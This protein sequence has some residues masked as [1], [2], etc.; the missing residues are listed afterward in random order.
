MSTLRSLSDRLS[1]QEKILYTGSAPTLSSKTAVTKRLP[2][3]PQSSSCNN[4]S[5]P[6]IL[7]TPL[8]PHR[9]TTGR[10]QYWNRWCFADHDVPL[11]P[12]LYTVAYTYDYYYYYTAHYIIC[13]IRITLR[14]LAIRCFVRQSNCLRTDTG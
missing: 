2:G 6:S 3:R 10:D 12:P 5:L 8:P 9:T 7:T 1:T 11:L 13:I 14:R 4:H